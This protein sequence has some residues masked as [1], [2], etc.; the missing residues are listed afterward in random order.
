MPVP[1]DYIPAPSTE[2]SLKERAYNQI[3]KW[4]VNGTLRPKEKLIPP[5]LA[6]VLHIHI[7]AVR[8]ALQLLEVQEF[9]IKNQESRFVVT[10]INK[11]N[12]KKI[13]PP[14]A[15]LQALAAELASQHI[16]QTDIDCL[17]QINSNFARALKN[18]NPLLALIEDEN[19]HGKIIEFADNPYIEHSIRTLEAH[20][21]RLF[22]QKSIYLTHTSIQE[23]E[24]IIIAFEQKDK[25]TSS[26]TMS[27]NWLRPIEKYYFYEKNKENK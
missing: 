6:E 9:V 3:L 2:L 5:Q 10:E 1:F 12:I 27:K 17:R 11:A 24:Q 13:L 18:R 14:L 16:K 25:V 23:H 21:R 8:E 26:I 22:F 4:I 7:D 20:V 15:S 19:F